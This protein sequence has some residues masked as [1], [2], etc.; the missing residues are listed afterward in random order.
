MT[1]LH[2]LRNDIQTSLNKYN[3]TLATMADYNKAFDTVI[4]STLTKRLN[5][6]KFSNDFIDFM[7]DHLS[8]CQRFVEI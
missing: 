7:F 4:Y 5:V 2:K 6:I 3:V 1:V 8:D